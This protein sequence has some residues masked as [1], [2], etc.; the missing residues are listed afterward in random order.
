L[1]APL[2][3]AELTFSFMTL[4]WSRVA[5][6]S[7][8]IFGGLLAAGALALLSRK[9]GAKASSAERVACG[10]ILFSLA[11]A[12]MAGLGRAGVEEP[13]KLPIRYSLLMAPFQVG[14]VMLA[15]PWAARAWRN[16]PGRLQ[17]V[18]LALL[19]GVFAQHVAM[20]VMAVEASDVIRNEIAAF[21]AGARTPHMLQ[22]IHP[23]LALAERVSARLRQ[24]GLF[25]HELHLK[26]GTSAR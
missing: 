14:L 13:H 23:N 12:A 20:A 24:Q 11:A 25:Q 7:A 3:I 6:H 19:I 2:R 15:A 21:H 5:L 8:W 22:L 18:S 17:G 9:G 10:L 16:S 4:P 26:P 1:H